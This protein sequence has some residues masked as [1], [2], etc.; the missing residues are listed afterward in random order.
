M[1][2]RILIQS[3]SVLT[4]S[5]LSIF[6][7][8]LES[9]GEGGRLAVNESKQ[10]LVWST[11]APVPF[12]PDFVVSRPEK[13]HGNSCVGGRGISGLGRFTLTELTPCNTT[14]DLQAQ[15]ADGSVHPQGQ[16]LSSV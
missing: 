3:L 6:G 4:I 13:Q 8:I 12:N 7:F 10:P 9:L 1:K 15:F 2:K 5:L 11:E 14:W 16:D